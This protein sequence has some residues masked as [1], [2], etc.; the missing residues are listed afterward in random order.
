LDSATIPASRV[1]RVVG[2]REVD[3]LPSDLDDL[4][5]LRAP[6]PETREVVTDAVKRAITDQASG[7]D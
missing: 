3:G 5:H 4:G 2:R 1:C 7:S 6:S